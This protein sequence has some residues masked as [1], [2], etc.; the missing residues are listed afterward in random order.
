MH[1]LEASVTAQYARA[2]GPPGPDGSLRP[3]RSNCRQL[4]PGPRAPRRNPT[5]KSSYGTDRK[6]ILCK[7]HIRKVRPATGLGSP[8]WPRIRQ[9]SP[10]F[11]SLAL[12]EI[13]H[14]RASFL[15]RAGRKSR[16]RKKLFRL[17]RLGAKATV[18]SLGSR[19][20]TTR[21]LRERGCQTPPKPRRT[22]ESLELQGVPVP[23]PPEPRT[24]QMAGGLQPR[25]VSTVDGPKPQT[26]ANRLQPRIKASKTVTVPDHRQSKP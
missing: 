11:E 16:R 21:F 26:V 14:W 2:G 12:A 13:P 18:L 7:V 20:Q 23:L 22:S 5:T 8:R 17:R 9:P 10:S 24:S 15:A 3:P 19:P 1:L 6:T 25:T 4:S